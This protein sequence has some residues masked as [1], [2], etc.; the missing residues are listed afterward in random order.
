MPT[1]LSN[2]AGVLRLDGTPC[3]L[4]GANAYSVYARLLNNQ[5]PTAYISIFDMLAARGC[6]VVR[7]FGDGFNFSG[8]MGAWETSSA[9]AIAHATTLLDAAHARNMTILWCL[10]WNVVNIP[11]W[12]SEATSA[13]VSGTTASRTYLKLVVDTAVPALKNH[14]AL[15]GWECGNEIISVMT[16]AGLTV[17]NARTVQNDIRTWI[18]AQDAG[19]FVVSGTSTHESSTITGVTAGT[20]PDVAY[21]QTNLTHAGWE[22][23]STHNYCDR[24]NLMGPNGELFGQWLA[25]TAMRCKGQGQPLVLGEFGG[26]SSDL[27]VS[28]VQIEN[29][30]RGFAEAP[31]CQLGLLWN[32][33]VSDFSGNQAEFIFN[34][35]DRPYVLPLIGQ[36]A[37]M[38]YV[39][40]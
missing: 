15:A 39:G 33:D 27:A 11:V 6:R 23:Q 9:T 25:R 3:K 34:L 14:P 17:A 29:V 13:L 28:K 18:L 40:R 38:P 30:V 36:Y 19:S 20:V 7:V 22:S 10:H 31:H 16:Q 5:T 2:V 4:L 37:S 26:G 35:V 1:R 8:G 24:A 21:T 32:C 12:K